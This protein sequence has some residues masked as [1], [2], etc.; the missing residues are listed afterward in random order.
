MS[1][2]SESLS[3]NNALKALFLNHGWKEVTS[4]ENSFY[5]SYEIG[6]YLWTEEVDITSRQRLSYIQQIKAKRSDFQRALGEI[7]NRNA[8]VVGELLAAYVPFRRTGLGKL[9]AYRQGES[10]SKSVGELLSE[11]FVGKE[12]LFMIIHKTLDSVETA[13]TANTAEEA[14][15]HIKTMLELAGLSEEASTQRTD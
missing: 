11:D 3:S 14:L 13:I 12:K 15:I 7:A 6:S 5:R 4:L 10:L 1:Y 9:R 2:S 8:H